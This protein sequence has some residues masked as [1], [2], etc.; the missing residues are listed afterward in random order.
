MSPC[1]PD[2]TEYNQRFLI[3]ALRRLRASLEARTETVNRPPPAATVEPGP[4][5]DLSPNPAPALEVLTQTFGLSQFE[6]A[7]LLL[8]AGMELD[9]SFSAL[10]AKAQGEPSRPYPTFSL[11][12]AALPRAHWSALSPAAPLRRWRMIELTGG[13]GAA[14]TSSP[15]RID[16]RIL[17]YLT[18]IHYLD[19]RLAAILEPVP[20]REQLVPSH[21]DIATRTASALSMAPQDGLLPIP[22]VFGGDE[23][24]RRA[25]ASAACE[26]LGVPMRALAADAIP[27]PATDMDA[28]LRL[29]ERESALS[30][31]AVYVDADSAQT[32]EAAPHITRFL[33]RCA[34][35]LI[36][37]SRDRWKPMRRAVASIETP[38]PTREEQRTLW[39]EALS[40]TQ[41]TSNGHVQ[42]LTSQFNLSSP[43]ILASGGLRSKTP[44]ARRSRS[45]G[46]G[47]RPRAGAPANGRPGA[48]DRIVGLVGRPRAAR[49]R[50]AP[51]AGRLGSRQ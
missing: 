6:R 26:L 51:T 48:T 16:E 10:C 1:P 13:P 4:S 34:S 40:G 11:A 7:I 15:L 46:L 44:Y 19:E 32:G 31:L 45:A 9:S 2:W 21:R 37:S 33:E 3:E 30:S 41:L 38:K 23:P 18:G 24:A 49:K 14:L 20:A 50:I 8:C 12:L 39:Q 27:A 28:L 29:L 36:L 5:L 17:H 35:P 25:I 22:E 42:A 43:A 47:F